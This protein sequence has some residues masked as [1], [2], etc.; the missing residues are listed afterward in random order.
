MGFFGPISP[1]PL[2]ESS[3]PI[4]RRAFHRARVVG[5]F[6]AVQALVQVIGFFSGILLVRS[7]SQRE[8]AYFTIANTMQGTINLLAD[9]GIS[10]GLISIGGRVWQDRYRFGEL[11]NTAL[12]IRKKLGTLAIILITPVMYFMLVRN[13]SS[14]LYAGALI[15]VV[16][17]G[18]IVQLSLGV[19]SV[20]PRLR[21]DLNRIQI[22]DLT[23]AVTR[24]LLLGALFFLF[25]NAGIAVLVA[26]AVIL[27]QY[28]MLRAYVTRVVDF[29][30][31]ENPKDRSEIMRLTK[32]LAANAIFYCVQGQITVFLIGFFAQRANSVAEV[33]ALG[34]LAMIFTVVSN[35]LTNVF[36]PAFA[37]CNN[38]RKLKWLFFVIVGGVSLFSAVILAG[39]AFFPDQFLYVLGHKYTHLH[40]ELILMVAAAVLNAVAGTLWALN[41]SKA[42]VAG[43]WLY[44]PLTLT[45]QVALIPF[46]DFSS[47]SGV[48]TFNL[49]SVVPSLFLNVILSYRGFRAFR[50]VTA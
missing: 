3:A 8:Y 50:A 5:N 25:L 48:L 18:L 40:R 7:L 19:L 42:W 21:S 10:V 16:L 1:P 34:R 26:T 2:D 43:S 45:T 41:A 49:F 15:V 33:G 44:I 17:G 32:H 38:G 6:A 22:I 9:I 14:S 27:L 31:P 46:T 23:G 12:G 47:V 36:V 29:S 4:I 11:V 13:G 20:V 30:A 37:R 28:L 24:L 39:A 35:L